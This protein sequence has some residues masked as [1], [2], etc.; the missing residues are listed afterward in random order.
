MRDKLNGNDK[1]CVLFD[2]IFSRT[3][4]VPYAQCCSPFTT[5]PLGRHVNIECRDSF[6]FASSYYTISPLQNYKYN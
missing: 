6:Y 5:W 3:N 2:D 4:A 1:R